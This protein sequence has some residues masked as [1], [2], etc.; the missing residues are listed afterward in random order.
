MP[1]ERKFVTPDFVRLG[2][3]L[4]C[5]EMIRSGITAFADMYY[6]EDAIADETAVS[7]CALLGQ[8][9]LMF[10]APDAASYEDA[11][12]NCRRFIEKW[13]GHADTTGRSASC[14]VYEHA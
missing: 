10:P 2:T 13:N 3:R 11:V 1:V 4:A 8:T 5:A 12:V 7:V 14:L 9:I 6:F